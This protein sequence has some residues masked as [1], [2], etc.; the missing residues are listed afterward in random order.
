[1]GAGVE[2][3]VSVNVHPVV[4]AGVVMTAR[5]SGAELVGAIV[6]VGRATDR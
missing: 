3:L 4:D 5:M 2:V 1:V 6:R